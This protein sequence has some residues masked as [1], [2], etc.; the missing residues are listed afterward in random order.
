MLGF[1][2]GLVQECRF[3]GLWQTVIKH[4]HNFDKKLVVHD[5]DDERVFLI[6]GVKVLR[7]C[8]GALWLE[9]MK[10]KVFYVQDMI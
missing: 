3:V 4:V 6:Q 2:V 8:H 7:I 9:R 1:E 5:G 10:L